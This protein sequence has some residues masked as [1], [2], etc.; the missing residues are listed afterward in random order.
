ASRL[1]DGQRVNSWSI[2]T[3]SSSAPS[4]YHRPRNIVPPP[5]EPGPPC[6]SCPCSPAFAFHVRRKAAS[7]HRQRG[8]RQ[9]ARTGSSAPRPLGGSGS[10]GRNS[11]LDTESGR[12]SFRRTRP[13]GTETPPA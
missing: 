2:T 8:R 4:Q 5:F 7:G 13:A 11:V 9:R 12:K 1:G 6:S 3:H 10:I